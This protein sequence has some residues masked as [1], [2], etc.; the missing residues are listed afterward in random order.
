MAIPAGNHHWVGRVLVC[1]NV[2]HKPHVD[3]AGVAIKM[4]L[5]RAKQV[6]DFK[7]CLPLHA[8]FALV[9]S[10]AKAVLTLPTGVVLGYKD[11]TE[12]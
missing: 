3:K 9:G 8:K 4:D 5:S 1:I 10:I 7:C 2:D 12:N 6:L 11:N